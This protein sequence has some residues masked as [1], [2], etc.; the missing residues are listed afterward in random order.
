[1]QFVQGFARFKRGDNTCNIEAII[2]QPII[3]SV[4]E[5]S[6]VED[7]VSFTKKL[8]QLKAAKEDIM[9]NHRKGL[10]YYNDL[11]KAPKLLDAH[12]D[13]VVVPRNRRN[14]NNNNNNPGMINRLPTDNGDVSQVS[15]DPSGLLQKIKNIMK[16][17]NNNRQKRRSSN[18]NDVNIFDPFKGIEAAE[19][20]ERIYI[21]AVPTDIAT[22]GNS[23][24]WR[25]N[26]SRSRI[27]NPYSRSQPAYS[28]P[29]SESRIFV[30][31]RYN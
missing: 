20:R 22:E 18:N 27:Y 21:P 28:F 5:Q 25:P 3:P 6:P 17:N 11:H 9:D 4:N 13:P 16:E 8:A 7:P 26:S 14:N 1:L 19:S 2:T 29:T 24:P 12:D 15:D 10:L 23:S 30:S 31:P